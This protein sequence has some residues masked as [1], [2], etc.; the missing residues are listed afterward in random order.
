MQNIPGPSVPQYQPI[1]PYSGTDT[2][3]N[4]A[5]R[6]LLWTVLLFA[7]PATLSVFPGISSVLAL[8]ALVPPVITCIIGAVKSWNLRVPGYRKIYLAAF[9]LG[10]PI[11]AG[12]FIQFFAVLNVGDAEGTTFPAWASMLAMLAV[13]LVALSQAANLNPEIV[14]KSSRVLAN[15]VAVLLVGTTIAAFFL[16]LII[17]MGATLF[18]GGWVAFWIFMLIPIAI[19]ATLLGLL[20]WKS[21]K[22]RKGNGG[23]LIALKPFL[24]WSGVVSCMTF[25]SLGFFVTN[26]ILS[27]HSFS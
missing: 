4:E 20:I 6:W 10:I 16:P 12:I 5:G 15:T 11:V 3:S 1:Q 22:E 21:R 8:I 2:F 14:S 18:V 7:L 19:A 23:K 26:Y 17:I 13:S 25:I 24:M 27:G 9:L